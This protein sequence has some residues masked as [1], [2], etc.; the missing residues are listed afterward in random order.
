MISLSF[1]VLSSE[2]GHKICMMLQEVFGGRPPIRVR[3]YYD[4]AVI[5][6]ASNSG[7]RPSPV[8]LLSYGP[9]V[10]AAPMV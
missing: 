7:L 10:A 5:F 4:D 6:L 2:V 1:T 9:E 3:S 8:F